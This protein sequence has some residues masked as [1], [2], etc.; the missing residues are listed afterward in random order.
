MR[1]ATLIRKEILEHLISYRTLLTAV[2]C[3][4][5]LV[6]SAVLMTADYA[7]RRAGYD[8]RDATGQTQLGKRPK[9][10]RA[11][12]PLSVLARGLDP[13]M[14][15]LL[16]MTWSQPRR[17]PGAKVLDSGDR[18]FLM[19]LFQPFDL[20]H[21]VGFVLSLLALFFSFD[22]ICGEKT[23]GTLRLLL[24]SSRSR[25]EIL[26]AKWIGGQVSLLACL[27][28]SALLLLATLSLSAD[29]ELGQEG[30]ARIG[31]ILLLSGF[32][33]S[34]FFSLGL[35]VS[36]RTHRPAT[37][38]QV[39]LFLWALW[40]LGVPNL[41]ILMAKGIQPVREVLDV[42]REKQAVDR[43]D[44]GDYM[45]YSRACW[46]LDDRYIAE[47]E[48]Q[49]GLCRDLSRLSP[50]SSYFYAATAL[51]W[52]GVPDAHDYRDQ[53]VQWDRRQREVGYNW[54][55]E[56]P[57]YPRRLTLEESVSAV[58]VDVALLVA[59]NALLLAAAY[60]S[61]LRYDVR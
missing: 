53:V 39:I 15:R 2:L 13:Q 52:T 22:G 35:L 29:L 38:L 43:R 17:D 55:G 1:S 34:V 60:I 6:S 28:P 49:V 46:H 54:A 9:L 11:P 23:S 32:F 40:V 26:L 57:F 18:N 21:I 41:G 24:A 4:V 50:L 14:G 8:G 10:T 7:S 33:I 56:I 20:V 45:A 12:S 61:F 3:F 25:G 48:A 58:W 37:S 5:L 16:T 42:E 27:L 19:S 31:L 51:S 59:L 44:Y 47:V 30:W 36:A